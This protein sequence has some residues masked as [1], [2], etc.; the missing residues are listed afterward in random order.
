MG[1]LRKMV[2]WFMEETIV[3]GE[4]VLTRILTEDE[5]RQELRM[6]R[7][8]ALEETDYLMTVDVYNTLTETQQNELTIYRQALRDIP[9]CADPFN[10]N[11]P[12]A[13]SWL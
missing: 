7:Q 11:Y 12:I 13:P 8:S 6:L 4:K 3:D 2:E 5:A 1:G 9:A 10:P